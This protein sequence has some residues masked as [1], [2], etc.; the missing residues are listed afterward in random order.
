[1]F[2]KFLKKLVIFLIFGMI[3]LFI[4]SI[5]ISGDKKFFQV[6]YYYIVDTR[7]V[8]WILE[9]I[10]SGAR[11]SENNAKEAAHEVIDKV[12]SEVKK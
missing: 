11:T 6:S 12:S 10:Y 2:K 4:F 8:H 1:M 3:W 9:K 5:P 7:P